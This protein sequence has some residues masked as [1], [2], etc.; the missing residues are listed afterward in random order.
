MAADPEWVASVEVAPEPTA[1]EI[2]SIL[3]NNAPTPWNI[4]NYFPI[5]LNRVIIFQ[6][7]VSEK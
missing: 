6:Y 3:A 1:T 4:K 5:G 2:L 7:Q